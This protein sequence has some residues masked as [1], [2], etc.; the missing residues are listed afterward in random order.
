MCKGYMLPNQLFYQTCEQGGGYHHVYDNSPFIS[1]DNPKQWLSQGY[2]FWI[3]DKELAFTWGRVA[4][5]NIY[6][7]VEYELDLSKSGQILDLIGSPNAINYFKSLIRDYLDKVHTIKDKNNPLKGVSISG[8]IRY[9]R[10]EAAQG[11]CK[12][13]WTG[14]KCCDIDTRLQLKFRRDKQECLALNN[15]HQLCLFDI[16]EEVISRKTL[17]HPAEWIA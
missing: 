16:N 4:K 6:S 3:E 14:I 15:R 10:A 2:Y 9:Y 5:K 7:I 12:F 13:P 8:I 11:K 1:E 17:I